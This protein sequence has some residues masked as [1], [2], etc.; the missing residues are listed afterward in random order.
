MKKIE[1]CILKVFILNWGKSK[2]C[3]IIQLYK[4]EIQC[5][6]RGTLFTQKNERYFI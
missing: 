1:I 3:D 6:P 5:L 4:I 2:I